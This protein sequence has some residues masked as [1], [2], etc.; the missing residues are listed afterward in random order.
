MKTADSG[1]VGQGVVR[2]DGPAKVTGAALYVDDLR[3]DGCWYGATV[4][5][6]AAYARI[7]N[8]RFAAGF[9]ATGIA[10]VTAK[11][12]PG[13]NIV[14]L[15]TADQP[16]LADGLVKHT[17]E[18]IALVAAD[19]RERALEAARNVV[20][21]ETPIEPLFDPEI[22]RGH[23][24][25]L[26][27]D[28]NVFSHIVLRHGDADALFDAP[29]QGAVVVEGVYTTG[30][31]EQLYI[32]PQGMLAEPRPD[33][34]LTITGSMQC[35]FYI[36]DA[37]KTVL[38][39]DRF[40]VVQAATG[41]GFGGKEEYPSLVAI[42]AC[43]LALK[44][45]RPIKLIY[46]RDEDLWATTKRHPMRARYRSV[47]DTASGKLLA[48]TADILFDGGAYNTLSPV[49][50][51][52]GVIHAFGPYVCEHTRAEALMV[53]TNTPPNGAFRGFGAPQVQWA[54]E[55]H[56]DRI[57][58]AL[59][60][61]PVAVRRVNLYRDGD[62]TPTGQTLHDVGA[63]QVLEAALER[64][65]RP[66]PESLAR[67]RPGGGGSAAR[68]AP[69]RGVALAWH[70]C[71]FTGNGEAR[72]M[73]KADVALEGEDVVI[74]ISSTDIGQGTET[75]FPQIVADTL[76][77]P[78][79]RVSN[80]PHDTAQVPDSGPTVASRTAM[81]VGRVA[82]RAAQALDA[83]LTAEV[84]PG[85]TFA[86][87]V[88]RRTSTAPLRAHAEYQDAGLQWDPKTYQGDAYPTFGWCAVVVDLDVDLDTGEVLYRRL[89][90]ATDVGRALN[91]VLCSGQLEGGALQA[92]GYA[93]S[94]EVVLDAQGGMRNNRLTNYIIPTALDAPE[95]ETVLI[96]IPFAEGPF[97]AKGIGEIPHDVPHAAVAQAIEAATGAVL[98]RLPM[99]PERVMTAMSDAA[100]GSAR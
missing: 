61:D 86:E 26:F 93:T 18:A 65:Q 31:Q 57:A 80:A 49:V 88:A 15:M 2:A 59:G 3:P 52:R 73:G 71:G 46:R 33:G 56:M 9:D 4:R 82:Q 40:N 67:V 27:G 14:E 7:A 92:L 84:G 13:E 19:T 50:N 60:M 34:G 99:V 66:L 98:D 20:F 17:A 24:T 53:A 6:R 21:D 55:R 91:P 75:I 63:Q 47:V 54:A 36:V 51:S 35:P 77:Y 95:M 11:D 25:R 94:E 81:V 12:I 29:P 89:V 23:A 28:D 1:V 30:L 39:H 78:L 72:L 44:T 76:G 85:G 41:G 87:R 22:A 83:L 97:G 69:G 42:H 48:Q 79:A 100:G 37:L 38:G 32:E 5:A 45:G 62:V 96:E 90:Q 70:G 8:I 64:A 16:A 74:Y 43:L 58:R 10:L 68:L